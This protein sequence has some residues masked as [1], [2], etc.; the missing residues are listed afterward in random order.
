MV[1]GLQAKG[2]AQAEVWA[3]AGVRVE[4]EW[5]DRLQQGRA[6]IVYVLT[7]E[8]RSLMLPDSLVMRKAVLSVV[9]K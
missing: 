1:Q 7:V 5:A 6:V 8:Q 4:A 9:R 3:K 2:P